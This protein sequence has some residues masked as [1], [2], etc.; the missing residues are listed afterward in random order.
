LLLRG[1]VSQGIFGRFFVSIKMGYQ[2]KIF[3]SE[4]EISFD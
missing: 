3:A 1:A 4:W 2:K